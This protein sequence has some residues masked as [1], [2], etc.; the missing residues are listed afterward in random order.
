M[1]QT[2]APPPNVADT[3]QHTPGHACMNSNWTAAGTPRKTQA[4]GTPPP[5]NSSD[6][7]MP[8]STTSAS[9]QL[10]H[11]PTPSTSSGPAQLPQINSRGEKRKGDNS[12]HSYHLRKRPAAQKTSHYNIYTI[13]G[14]THILLPCGRLLYKQCV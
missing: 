12:T 7:D 8:L 6:V 13:E 3:V 9:T 1:Q 2:L 14:V 11:A 5:L 4:K 10:L